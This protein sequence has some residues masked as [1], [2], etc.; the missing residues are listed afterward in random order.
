MKVFITVPAKTALKEIFEYYKSEGLEAYARQLTQDIINKA[1][2][3]SSHYRRGQ[4]EEILK[5]LHKGHRYLLANQH[6]KII[7]RQEGRTV[8]V[9]DVFDTRQKP[10]R[11]IKRSS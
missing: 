3:L 5:P 4:E 9:T 8:I 10:E 2:S 11:L 6:Y 1:K 7:Y